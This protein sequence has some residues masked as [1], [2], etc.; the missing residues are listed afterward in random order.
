MK[1]KITIVLL[2]IS[3]GIQSQNYDHLIKSNQKWNV[4]QYDQATCSC[5]M[6]STHSFNIGNDTIVD[7]INY[8]II[9]D[10]LYTQ[11]NNSTFFTVQNFG[12]VRED[13]ITKKIYFKQIDYYENFPEYLIYDFNLDTN[14]V[15]I[16]GDNTILN[17]EYVDSIFINNKYSKRIKFVGN[18]LTWI[19][20]LGA[21]QGL[22]YAEFNN[23]FLNR[24][25]LCYW[26]NDSLIYSLGDTIYNCL[27]VDFISS[28]SK[29][30]E[31]PQYNI[32]P[33]PLTNYLNIESINDKLEMKIYDINGKI[34]FY[35]KIKT[36]QIRIDMSS[37]ENGFYILSIN[38]QRFKIIKN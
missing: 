7:S 17:V 1:T 15:F 35:N 10:T 9:I 19:E 16:F 23:F 5:A 28:I 26:K 32:Y 31:L 13:T 20:G 34:L 21:L 11:E 4:L 2:I 24:T 30:S 33:N 37:F 25:L 12:L 18:E 14:S 29:V 6:Y 22:I 27:Y 8:K 38:N 3:F 36:N